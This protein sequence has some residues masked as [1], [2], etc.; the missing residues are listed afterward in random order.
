MRLLTTG[1]YRASRVNARGL[2]DRGVKHGA[3]IYYKNTITWKLRLGASD[4]KTRVLFQPITGPCFLRDRQNHGGTH[5]TA[6]V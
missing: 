1:T 5:C 4:T 2:M 6:R 3:V